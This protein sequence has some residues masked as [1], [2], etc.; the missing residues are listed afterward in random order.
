MYDVFIGLWDVEALFTNDSCSPVFGAALEST[1][2]H[3]YFRRFG[4]MK[5]FLT[6]V[7]VI[8]QDNESIVYLSLPWYL[9]SYT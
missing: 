7:T 8:G 9:T 1:A 4:P 6:R 3:I 5:G 2:P